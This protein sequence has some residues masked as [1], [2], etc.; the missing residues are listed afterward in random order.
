MVIIMQLEINNNLLR[1][2]NYKQILDI[3]NDLIILKNI[4]IKGIN[5]KVIDLNQTSI[6]I[7]GIFLN[8]ELAYR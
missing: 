3:N 2:D 8:L 7:K 4:K 1:V 6:I 5:L